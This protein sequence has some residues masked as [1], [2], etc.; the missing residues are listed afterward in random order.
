MIG[1]PEIYNRY[2]KMSTKSMP[3]T[4]G[5]SKPRKRGNIRSKG[6]S[7]E[8]VRFSARLAVRRTETGVT[9]SERGR[10]PAGNKTPKDTSKKGPTGNR[11]QGETPKPNS[12][13]SKA[14][15]SHGGDSKRSATAS[16]HPPSGRDERYAIRLTAAGAVGR[17]DED[18][19]E[20]TEPLPGHLWA[21]QMILEM[22][23]PF[24]A[25]CLT[26]AVTVDP[27]GAFLFARQRA[28]H[29]G[30]TQEEAEDILI[31]FL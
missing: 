15:G 16:I 14:P 18:G 26:E 5:S 12:V 19:N 2:H 7:P 10:G 29:Q 31:R 11:A 3:N 24:V 17:L 23:Q 9:Q 8:P 13:H 27:T 6:A 20:I 21:D 4:R 30:F 25:I 1:A 28:R 22:L